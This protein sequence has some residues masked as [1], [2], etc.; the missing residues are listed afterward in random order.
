M[1]REMMPAR[2][3]NGFAKFQIFIKTPGYNTR[4]NIV[5]D[6]QKL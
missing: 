1:S 3:N 6:L 5:I 2:I 4:V